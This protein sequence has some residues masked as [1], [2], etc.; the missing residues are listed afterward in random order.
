MRIIAVGAHPDD[1]EFGCF[2][3]LSHYKSTGHEIFIVLFTSGELL[4]NIDI[5]ESEAKRSADLINAD[6]RFFRFSDANI[7]VNNETIDVFRNYISD[8]RPDMIFVHHPYDR[9]QDHKATNEICLSSANSFNKILFYEGPSTFDF[10]PNIYFTIDE[11]FE[12]KVNGLQTFD[13]QTNKPYIS[14][15]SLKALAQYRAYQCGRYGH[16]CEAFYCY[17]WIEV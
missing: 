9:H 13:S 6:I 5:R 15:E 10:T 1:I 17:K 8:I 4:E 11:Y 3:T 12:K 7:K 2:S 14:V 16:L